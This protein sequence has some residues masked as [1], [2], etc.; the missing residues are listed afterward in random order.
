MKERTLAWGLDTW[1]P[2]SALPETRN[3]MPSKPYPHG[4]FAS[5]KWSH[6]ERSQWCPLC[7]HP[8]LDL[9]GTLPSGCSWHNSGVHGAENHPPS[10]LS[11]PNCS[12]FPKFFF[13]TSWD[14]TFQVCVL[15]PV[16]QPPWQ[17]RVCPAFPLDSPSAPPPMPG[18]SPE[19]DGAGGL[20]FRFLSFE[21][22][23]TCFD[24]SSSKNQ[25]QTQDQTSESF[26]PETKARAVGRDRFVGAGTQGKPPGPQS[27]GID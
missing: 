4:A 25:S 26:D 22:S 21:I 12:N 7:P 5:A 16:P 23:V 10:P 15:L 3:V 20:G 13:Y 27:P 19:T 8:G 24:V 6:R 11:C 2:L 18:A 14:Q 9:A 17:G 1:A